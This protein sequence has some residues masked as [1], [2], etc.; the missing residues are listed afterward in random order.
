MTARY[1]NDHNGA[2]EQTK[3]ESNAI[4]T[5]IAIDSPV[6]A[7]PST[8]LP[9][10]LHALQAATAGPLTPTQTAIQQDQ[11]TAHQSPQSQQSQLA[12]SLSSPNQNYSSLTT[13]QYGGHTSGTSGS[14]VPITL[15]SGPP[16]TPVA[17]APQSQKAT[18]LRRACDM[19]SKRKVKCDDKGP[20]CTPCA[21]LQLDCT[22][23]RE[24]KRRGPPNKHAEAARLAKKHRLEPNL[25][26][27]P[28]GEILSPTSSS[29]GLDAEMI[30][31]YPVLSLLVD[32]F[33]TYIHPLIPFPHEP[34][35]RQSFANREDRTSREFLALLASMIGCLVASFPR[36]AREHLRSLRSTNLFPH[37]ITMI[38]RCRAV[39]IE[40]RG[41]GFETKREMTVYDAATSYFLG[42][43][44][45]YTLQWQ[46]FRRFLSQ[47]LT[48]IR[49]LGYHTKKHVVERQTAEYLGPQQ[50]KPVDHI[51]EE[52]GKRVFW[53]LLVGV[54]SMVQL[55]APSTELFIPIHTA[56]QPY[57]DLPLE[58]DD[59]YIM[60]DVIHPQ[61]EGSVSLLTGFNE[62]VKIYMTMDPILAAEWS[63]YYV[64][65][66]TW[67]DQRR[68]FCEVLQS[69]KDSTAKL[70]PELQLKPTSGSVCS[71]DS[72]F[73]AAGYQYYPPAFP[74]SQP[75]NDLRHIL[76]NQPD[77]R[78]KIQFEIQKANI[79]VS[80][81][82]TR[83]FYVE[84]YFNF[85]DIRAESLSK[86][87]VLANEGLTNSDGL[88]AEDSDGIYKL[89]IDETSQSNADMAKE[90]DTIVEGLLTVL[91][92]ISQR[93]L[94]PNGASVI[95]KIRQVASTLLQERP[96]RKGSL[97]QKAEAYLHHFLDILMKLEK[98]GRSSTTYLSVGEMTTQDEEEELRV[99]A[100]LRDCQM[101]FAEAG[102][103]LGESTAS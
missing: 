43:A 71:I 66:L 50:P 102:G 61:P 4:A 95:N 46:L 57:P 82:A 34:S 93:N 39:A 20:P 18:R 58:I 12:Q 72:E 81:L 100:D 84:K 70:T 62:C 85:F 16:T 19:C 67:L 13:H 98:T 49:E 3:N 2:A 45:G 1:G 78:R 23:N 53:V 48:I 8:E 15:S 25:S 24:M 64:G 14:P 28:A 29:D 5:S 79:F 30:G 68:M 55:G 73:D 65:G 38:E 51:K 52:V 59:Q 11:P 101:R 90:R 63:T 76:A 41:V 40:A 89:K 6:E 80:Q 75:D 31:P 87:S 21:E 83:S 44:A 97:A 37:S 33:F 94:E 99:W 60:A 22:R 88:P 17:L 69:A 10:G 103:F 96:D 36:S 26:L 91:A 86:P 27:S 77:K 54:R 9:H 7:I 47:S 92:S 42:L 56:N 74:A 35:F 32:D